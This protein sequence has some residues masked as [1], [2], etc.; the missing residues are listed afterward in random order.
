MHKYYLNKGT[1]DYF[2]M[3]DA[4]KEKQLAGYQL[5]DLFFIVPSAET[6]QKFSGLKLRL[7]IKGFRLMVW[8]KVSEN[9]DVPFIPLDDTLELSFLLKSKN[10]TFIQTT[11]L[12]LLNAGQLFFFSNKHLATEDAGFPL[13]KKENNTSEV[14]DSYLLNPTSGAN[15]LNQLSADEKKNLMGI[16]RICIKGENGGYHIL[17]QD[18]TLRSEHRIYN[19]VFANRKTTWRY[20]FESDQN[21]TGTDDLKKEGGNARQLVTLSEKPLTASGFVSIKLGDQELPN[22]DITQIKPNDDLTKIYS[23]IYM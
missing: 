18:G 20:F 17:K 3:D 14:N 15:E 9:E 16:I 6:N 7:L 5:S 11:Q 2:S 22:P 21:V 1:I 8:L 4:E 23:E 19:I 12:G 10:N 13:I